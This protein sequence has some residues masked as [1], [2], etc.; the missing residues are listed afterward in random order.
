MVHRHPGRSGPSGRWPAQ[1]GGTGASRPSK[2]KGRWSRAEGART[3][4]QRPLNPG[5]HRLHLQH[6]VTV[7]AIQPEMRTGLTVHAGRTTA[8]HRDRSRH[9]VVPADRR[10]QR[11]SGPPPRPRRQGTARIRQGARWPSRLPPKVLI[12]MRPDQRPGRNRNRRHG[13]ASG[14]TGSPEQPGDIQTLGLNPAAD[15]CVQ[16]AGTMERQL[17]LVGHHPAGEIKAV[18][19]EPPSRSTCCRPIPC[20]AR[21]SNRMEAFSR[22]FGRWSDPAKRPCP[23]S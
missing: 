15:R 8:D 19:D 1:G 23:D 16:A 7:T 13:T 22:R 14:L 5:D 4:L 20:T 3:P 9:P 12:T 11:A 17:A 6:P 2:A 18:A 21:A 10:D